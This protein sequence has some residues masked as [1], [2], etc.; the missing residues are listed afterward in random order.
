VGKYIRHSEEYIKE[1][2]RLI[3]EEHWTH[4]Q[5]AAA[6]D[7][8]VNTVAK[9]VSKAKNTGKATGVFDAKDKRIRELEAENKRLEKELAFSKKVAAWL[10]TLQER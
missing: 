3:T 10:A 2:V 1:S 9:W 7:V 8:H 5:V 4:A 6:A